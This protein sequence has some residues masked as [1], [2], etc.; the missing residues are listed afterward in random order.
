MRQKIAIR[1]VVPMDATGAC[2]NTMVNTLFSPPL[3]FIG[4]FIGSFLGVLV[5]RIPRNESFFKGR[6][7]CEQCKKVLAVLDLIP[8]FSFLSL[9]GRCRYCHTPLPFFYPIIELTTACLFALSPLLVAYFFSSFPLWITFI[10]VLCLIAGLIEIFFTDAK[11][12][13]IPDAVLIPL[14]LLAV[15]FIAFAMPSALLPNLASGLGALFLFLFLFFITRGRGMGLGDVKFAFFLG[16]LLGF[17][18]TIYALYIAFL[19]GAGYS[20]ILVLW[21]KKSFRG[22]TIPFGPFL[23]CGI[24]F[25]LLF[26]N[27]LQAWAMQYF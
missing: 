16:V 14:T 13:I 25:T 23:I 1:K 22:S 15:G 6:S 26:I 7:H 11:Y 21:R 4:L 20:L 24:F 9:R 18:G 8:V 27:Q 5:D 3:F 12:G 17:P 10:F 19:T 2:S